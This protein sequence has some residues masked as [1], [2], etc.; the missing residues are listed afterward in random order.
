MNLLPPGGSAEKDRPVRA[1]RAARPRRPGCTRRA[2]PATR[3][4]T[5]VSGSAPD[6][7]GPRVAWARHGRRAPVWPPRV[8]RQAPTTARDVSLSPA[9]RRSVDGRPT[10]IAPSCGASARRPRTGRAGSRPP[11]AAGCCFSE[12][13]DRRAR[14]DPRVPT[15]LFRRA[16]RKWHCPHTVPCSWFR[17]AARGRRS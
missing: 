9:T 12:N 13:R 16:R 17:P 6:A 4:R 15:T 7:T 14:P 10:R 3:A 1:D 11:R 2:G 5:A 8:L